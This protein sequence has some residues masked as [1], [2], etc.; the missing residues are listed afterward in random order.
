MS[1]NDRRHLFPFHKR[2]LPFLTVDSTIGHDGC[3]VFLGLS[4][5]KANNTFLNSF[6]TN[7]VEAQVEFTLKIM[8]RDRV[9]CY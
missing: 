5:N 7:E 4:Y 2:S 9:T 1:R 6:R 8:E 3:N